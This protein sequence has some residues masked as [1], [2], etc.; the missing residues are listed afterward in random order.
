[1]WS[2]AFKQDL[3][4]AGGLSRIVTVRMLATGLFR[5]SQAA[6]A[7]HPLLGTLVKQLNHLVTGADIAWQAQL[8]PGLALF[9]PTGVVVGEHVRA[10]VRCTIQQ[11]VTLGGLGGGQANPDGFPVL[12]DDVFLGA[13]CRV[14]GPVSVGD[15][16][17]VGANAVVVKDV[18][19]H[20]VAVGIP[21]RNREAR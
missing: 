18:P 17:K 9:H 20:A 14:I 15:G 4:R 21:A 3:V 5:L 12:G 8:G 2:D 10:G 13:G 6:G 16:A 7:K 1:M 19:P 11:G